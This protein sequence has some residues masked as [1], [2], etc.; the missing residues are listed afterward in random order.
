MWLTCMSN[1]ICKC[2]EVNWPKLEYFEVFLPIADHLSAESI[3]D[4]TYEEEQLRYWEEELEKASL[5]EK[6]V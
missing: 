6:R 1:F 2:Y 3:C 4:S 5:I